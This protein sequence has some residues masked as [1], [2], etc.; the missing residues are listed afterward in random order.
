MARSSRRRPKTRRRAEPSRRTIRI[1]KR[2][3]VARSSA[4]TLL[5]E[6]AR[7]VSRRAAALERAAD[8]DTIVAALSSAYA[9]DAPLANALREDWLR[10][11]DDKTARLTLAWAREQVRLAL[12]EV[13]QRTRALRPLRTGVD[14]EIL[15]WLWLAACEALAHEPASA[16]S[17]RAHA[18]ATFLHAT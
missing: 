12:S 10:G 2:A 6:V 11:R 5:L 1:A 13:L 15:A 17:D 4:E 16:A 8:V 14:V 9:P 7:D 3:A 18:L